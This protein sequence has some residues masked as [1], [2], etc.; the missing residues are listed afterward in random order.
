MDRLTSVEWLRM[1]AD[2]FYNVF[3]Q[4]RFLEAADEIE[5][6]REALEIISCKCKSN[7]GKDEGNCLYWVARSALQQ[8]ESE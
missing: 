1:K 4:E 8:K 5:R 3:E 7:C 2:G 6:L